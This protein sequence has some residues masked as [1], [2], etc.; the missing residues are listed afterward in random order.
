MT[1]SI[2]IRDYLNLS[3]FL[4]FIEATSPQFV[5][6]V[7]MSGELEKWSI[8]SL[9]GFTFAIDPPNSPCAK[10]S[11]PQALQTNLL[12]SVLLPR[13]AIYVKLYRKKVAASSHAAAN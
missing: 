7:K 11:L 4:T 10:E 6:I 8:S 9:M 5:Q 13:Y 3:T 2:T 1:Q 12:F